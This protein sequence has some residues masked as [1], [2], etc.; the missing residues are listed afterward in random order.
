MIYREYQPPLSLK[1]CIKCYWTME[2]EIPTVTNSRQRLLTEGFEFIF[3][4]GEPIEYVIGDDSVKTIAKTGIT[5]PMI[6]PMILRPTGEVNLFGICFRPGGSYPFIKT[7]ANKLINQYSDIG[8]IFVSAERKFTEHIHN[9]YLTINSRVNAVNMYLLNLLEKSHRDE[10]IINAATDVIKFHKG[11]ISIDQLA[12]DLGMSRRNMDRKFKES[13]GITPKQLCRNLRFKEGYKIIKT[14]SH[15]SLVDVAIYCG[16]YDQA[17]LIN[18]FKHF[19]GVSP[20][21]FFKTSKYV[22]D[23]FTDNF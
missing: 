11:N 12:T 1:D 14:S 19:T 20:I 6:R 2:S 22:P 17:H 16:Y 5:G 4:L 7:P 23:F 8:D 9:D 18:E 21:K 3:N 10:T 13:I 15:I